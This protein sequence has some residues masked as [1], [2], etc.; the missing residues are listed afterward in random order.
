MHKAQ[1][2]RKISNIL[3]RQIEMAFQYIFQPSQQE[4]SKL[5][6]TTS[7]KLEKKVKDRKAQT[8]SMSVLQCGKGTPILL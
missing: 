3:R 6:Q 2:P 1:A 8:T 5:Q 7:S 4:T